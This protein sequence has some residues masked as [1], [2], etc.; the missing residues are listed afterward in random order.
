MKVEI[1]SD[2]ACPWCYIGEKRFAGALAE[3]AGADQ[4]EVVFRPYQLNPEASTT[5]APPIQEL[6]KKFGFQP[7]V[8]A[9]AAREQLGKT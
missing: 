6:Q 4:V 8:V 7:D 1:Y 3:F 5:P 2:I 9:K